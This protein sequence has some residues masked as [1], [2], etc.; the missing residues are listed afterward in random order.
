MGDWALSSCERQE[1][2]V[3]LASR[4]T[5][6]GKGSYVQ[7]TAASGFQYSAVSIQLCSE[8]GGGQCYLADIAIGAAAAE[9]VVV[10]N[11]LF[12]ST[13]SI[14]QNALNITIPICIPAGVRIS[15]RVQEVGGAGTR[16]V[17]VGLVGR[18]GGSNYSQAQAGAAV[19]YGANTA[20]TNGVLVDPGATANTFGAW[21]ELTSATTRDHAGLMTVLGTNQQSGTLVD[22]DFN[23]QI[24][25]GTA[26]SEVVISEFISSLSSNFNR[27]GVNLFDIA[28]SIPSGSRLAMRSKCTSSAAGARHSTAIILGY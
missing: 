6:N 7:L 5:A 22:A 13:R 3:V 23:F 9:Q 27:L 18:A 12:D 19:N 1:F 25:I 20:T 16:D 24:G 11:I 14:Y 4:G 2:F 28:A 26:G 10:P 17:R 15:V 21:A 8:G